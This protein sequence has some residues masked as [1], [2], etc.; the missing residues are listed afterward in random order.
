VRNEGTTGSSVLGHTAT[1][2]ADDR[3]LKTLET[4][5]SLAN[6]V[7]GVGVD[8]APFCVSKE[9][10]QSI[11]S[12]ALA[13]LIRII[14]ELLLGI[15]GII[16]R[17]VG[18]IL[19]RAAIEARRSSAWVLLAIARLGHGTIG[20]VV[21]ARCSGK[22]LQVSDKFSA[23]S[24]ICSG[25]SAT[26]RLGGAHQHAVISVRFDVLLEI[27]GSLEGLAAEVAFVRLEGHV[28]ANV[29]GDV[30]ALHGGSSAVAPLAGKVEVVC[31]LTANMALTDVVIELLRRRATL[32]AVEPLADK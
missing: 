10:I 2:A 30:V 16:N 32:A 31:A 20:T 1:V 7:V 21:S 24:L 22:R 28:N 11:V 14:V 4:H 26:V 3:E 12:S 13:D 19:R 15:H 27:L 9:L 23:L 5:E 17:A 29:G 25:G 18:R 6:V 8:V